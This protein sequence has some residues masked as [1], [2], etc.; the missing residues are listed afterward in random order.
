MILGIQVYDFV[1]EV[2]RRTNIHFFLNQPKILSFFFILKF[3]NRFYTCNITI[4]WMFR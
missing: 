4:S 2:K 1:R 3:D